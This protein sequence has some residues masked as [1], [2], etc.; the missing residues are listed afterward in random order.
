MV[1]MRWAVVAEVRLGGEEASTSLAAAAVVAA[2]PSPVGEV[3]LKT[4][5]LEA[6]AGPRR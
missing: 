1:C 4:S 6:S 5:L 3:V 2:A